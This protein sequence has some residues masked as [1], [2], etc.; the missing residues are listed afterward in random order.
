MDQYAALLSAL[1]KSSGAVAVPR[2]GVRRG[3]H[4]ASV[5]V[6]RSSASPMH[7]A[8]HRLEHDARSGTAQSAA[9][10]SV[11]RP[12]RA[13][14][15]EPGDRIR[16][17]HAD[18]L[19]CH[20]PPRRAARPIPVHAVHAQDHFSTVRQLHVSRVDPIQV[21]QPDLALAH[22]KHASTSGRGPSTR[23]S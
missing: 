18:E 16:A 23:W 4:T 15:D 8:D 13:G 1:T 12:V 17:H 22:P 19:D 5:Y 14:A 6:D 3:E 21:P 9:I 2:S 7:G 20:S 11:K 10:R